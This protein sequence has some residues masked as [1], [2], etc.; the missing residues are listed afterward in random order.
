MSWVRRVLTDTEDDGRYRSGLGALIGA[1]T[2][3]VPLLFGRVG[4]EAALIAA[5]SGSV[6]A[7]VAVPLWRPTGGALDGP[8]TIIAN[9]A[10]L[11][12]AVVVLR[13]LSGLAFFVFVGGFTF[14]LSV[15]R[16]M[17]G[18]R[19]PVP[20]ASASELELRPIQ[21]RLVLALVLPLVA[22]A[23]VIV[24]GV[25]AELGVFR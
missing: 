19:N 2:V 10:F 11:V 18:W 23:I 20:V 16:F 24:V 22:L 17:S 4:A 13:Q 25:S 9:V 21:P 1:C 5:L 15:L 3:I 6:M 7:V 12:A 14:T 8:M